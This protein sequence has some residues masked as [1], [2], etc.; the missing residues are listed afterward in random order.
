MKTRSLCVAL[1]VLALGAPAVASA[2][3]D[4]QMN[5][6][7]NQMSNTTMPG[8]YS[9]ARRGV[10]SSGGI[11]IRNQTQPLNL[12]SWAPAELSGG[13][14]GIDATFGSLSWVSSA[15]IEQLMRN[16]ASNAEGLLFQ[17]ALSAISHDLSSKI[18]QFA[19]KAL[20]KIGQLK[21]S[22]QIAQS[23]ISALDSNAGGDSYANHDA[24]ASLVQTGTSSDASAAEQQ[25]NPVQTAAASD[26]KYK[27]LVA[28]NIMWDAI[29]SQNVASAFGESGSGAK[30]L[31]EEIMS[32]TGTIVTCIPSQDPDC[33]SG[34]NSSDGLG[35]IVQKPTL[36]LSDLVYGGGGTAQRIE[37]SDTKSCMKMSVVS[38]VGQGFLD[39]VQQMLGTPTS[40]GYL[41]TIFN[42]AS[43]SPQL[44]AFISNAGPAGAEIMRVA[45]ATNADQAMAYAQA[46]SRAIAVHLAY[47]M[48][49]EVLD[50]AGRSV[51]GA[52]GPQ[53]MQMMSM[54]QEDRQRLNDD[55][56]RML[57]LDSLD[58]Q[59]DELA[60]VIVNSAPKQYSG[61]S[62][63][64]LK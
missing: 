21:N 24:Q 38:W 48:M 1:A 59:M 32:V 63:A 11:T 51:Q 37:C 43:S 5:K 52:S 64:G 57:K 18:N 60:T 17:M 29:T 10:I 7:F 35:L 3:M 26:P 54:I 13:C 46:I 56:K 8:V 53:I 44:E 28:R 40:G 14:G 41:G 34:A 33:S 39:R 49:E 36:H 27:K 55:Y 22:C 19:D 9:N 12:V 45:R 31:N 6:M 50:S 47:H 62:N 23:A 2:G 15:Q 42:G 61:I 58:V 4:Q 20:S 30:T 16:V 25:Q